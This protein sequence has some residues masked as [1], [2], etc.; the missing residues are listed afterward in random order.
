M[1]LSLKKLLC[2]AGV[3]YIAMFSMNADDI[4]S[5]K[6]EVMEKISG[7][8]LPYVTIALAD[9]SGRVL[10]GATSDSSGVFILNVPS[11]AGIHAAA[12]LVYSFVGYR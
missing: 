10:G 7:I 5:L 8:P 6:G 2:L 12:S 11:G 9:T 3:I 1:K 4:R